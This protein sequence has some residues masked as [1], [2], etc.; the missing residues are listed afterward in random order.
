MFIH[1][2]VHS[3]YSFLDGAST[4]DSLLSCAGSFGM[5]A[6]AVTDHNNVSAAVQFHR[7]AKEYKIRPIQGAEVTMEDDSHLIL[8]AKNSKGYENLCR[9]L[10]SA[11][12]NSDRKQVRLSWQDLIKFNQHLICL[13]GCTQG[14]IPRLLLDHQYRDAEEAARRITRIFGPERFFIELQNLLVPGSKK[15]NKIL[16]ELAEKVNIPIVATNNVHF[17]AKDAFALHDVLTCVRNKSNLETISKLRRFNAENYLKSA[18]QMQRLFKEYPQALANTIKIAS[19]CEAALELGVNHL[20]TYQSGGKSLELL[21]SLTFQGAR[22]RYD[23]VTGEIRRRLEHELMV[24]GKLQVADYFLIVWDI[25]CYARQKQ[26]RFSGRGSAADSAVAYCLGFTNVDPISR[27]LLFERFLSLERAEKPDIDL[28]FDARFKDVVVAYVKGKYGKV[29]TASVCTFATYLA[30]M[31]IR[32]FGKVLGYLPEEIDELTKRMPYIPADGIEHTL[33]RI[34]ELRESNIDFGKFDMLFKLCAQAAGFPRHMGTHL[35]G[36]VIADVPLYQ[37]SPLQQ[38]AKGEQIIQFD[39]NDIEDLGLIKIDLL[40]L[41]TLSVVE[42][43]IHLAHDEKINIDYDAIPHDDPAT[44]SLLRSGNTVGVFQLESPA[45]RALQ[46]RLL[47]D[48]FEDLVASVALIRPGPISG[49]MVEPFIERRHGRSPITY[50]HPKLRDILAKTYGIVLFQEQV[51]EI[52]VEIAGFTP[53][54]ADRLRRTMTHY[55]SERE[56]QELGTHF[57]EKATKN[58]VSYENAKTIFSYI[59]G[60]AGYGFCEAHAASFADTAYRSA[61]LLCHYPAYYLAAM[62]NNQPMGYY[63]SHTLCVLA[64]SRGI[65]ILGVNI[66]KSQSGYTVWDNNIRVALKQVKGISTKELSLIEKNRQV[67]PFTSVLD[68]QRRVSVSRNT[69]ENLILAGAFDQLSPN[70]RR[71]LWQIPD[72]LK[73]GTPRKIIGEMDDFPLN[74]RIYHEY[75]VLGFSPTGHILTPLRSRLQ[76]EGVATSRELQHQTEG[77]W[78]KAGGIVIKPHR[79]PTKSGKTVVFLTLEDEFGLVDVVIFDDVYQKYGELIFLCPALI[80]VGR[81]Q[82]KHDT[83]SVVATQINEMNLA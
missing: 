50:L 21:R 79:P 59:A 77:K 67:S 75:K 30:R 83:V 7:L 47:P 6:I 73:V 32:D 55:R 12:L 24:I 35:G 72:I 11:H 18:E 81:I 22:K 68:F 58:G 20:P 25:V 16:V 26:I 36:V 65:Q 27:G 46:P 10:T 8:L 80:V 9:L 60:Y 78:V 37:L 43:T 33:T 74:Q 54:E 63:P 29:H 2:H 82:R 40:P 71:L 45:Q 39:K 44:Y 17:A 28:D 4:L 64:Q 56:M 15:L 38:A 62:L 42:D 51:I 70:R 34:P 66:N 53:G 14:L 57:V 5:P 52:A 3:P 69:L 19:Q 61:Y 13:S 23:K 41:R 1:L 48:S 49:D 31:A 76:E